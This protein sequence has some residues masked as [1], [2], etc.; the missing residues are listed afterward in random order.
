MT[1]PRT[2]LPFSQ[3]SL[4][5]TPL[6]TSGRPGYCFLRL[7]RV[8]RPAGLG[9]R[10]CVEDKCS[11]SRTSHA[12]GV[13]GKGL[14][15]LPR[16]RVLGGAVWRPVVWAALKT[17]GSTALCRRQGSKAG[18]QPLRMALLKPAGEGRPQLIICLRERICGRGQE[19]PGLH[20]RPPPPR[21]M[22]PSRERRGWQCLSPASERSLPSCANRGAH[23]A[24]PG[25][26][27]ADG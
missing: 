14:L 3:S 23:P 18:G 21:A 19:M 5:L 9:G 4:E 25:G 1:L 15:L 13:G 8:L 11:G 16:F 10:G 17:Q 12:V 24:A 22:L 7:N 26:G 2:F 20:A 27:A 6:L